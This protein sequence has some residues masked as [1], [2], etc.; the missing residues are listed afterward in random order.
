VFSHRVD[1]C[2][3][4]DSLFTA[5]AIRS[6]VM[7]GED[8]ERYEQTV[9]GLRSLERQVGIGT[10][11]KIA[12]GLDLPAVAAGVIATP[13]H[14]NRPMWVQVTGRMSRTAK[15]KTDAVLWYLWDQHVYGTYPLYNLRKWNTVVSIDINGEWISIEEFLDERRK[16]Q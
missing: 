4:L 2:R 14:N 11:G 6:G 16:G 15:G 3:V 13:C 8:P 10:F 12:L 7:L 9:M 5:Y 1:H